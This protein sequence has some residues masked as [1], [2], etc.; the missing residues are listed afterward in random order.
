MKPGLAV[1]INAA[2]TII[3]DAQKKTYGHFPS[4]AH[5]PDIALQS[6]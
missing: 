1:V 3:N 6:M 4:F 5:S 2:Q